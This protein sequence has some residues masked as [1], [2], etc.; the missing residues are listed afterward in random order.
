M[1]RIG[2]A[3][4]VAWIVLAC[5]SAWPGPAGSAELPSAAR[6]AGPDADAVF[7]DFLPRLNAFRQQQGRGGV[8]ANAQLT[9]AAQDF[10]HFL[11]RTGKLDHEA[12]GRTPADRAQAHGYAYCVVNENLAFEQRSPDFTTVEL[13]RALLEGWQSS[14]PHRRNML[15]PDVVET[16]FGLAKA[17]GSGRWYAVELFGTPESARIAFQVSNDSRATVH[18]RLGERRY[19]LPVRT[20]RRHL[21]CRPPKLAVDLPGQSPFTSQPRDGTHYDIVQSPADTVTVE[22]R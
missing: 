1:G 12:D 3:C 18:Y 4:G 15:D 7:R 10:A 19:E 11:A 14:P 20:T 13:A 16:G 6:R 2:K 9:A 8:V 17:E 21:E 5:A 22:V